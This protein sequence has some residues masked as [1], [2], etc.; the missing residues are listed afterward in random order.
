MD[1][2]LEVSDAGYLTSISP[3]AT[4]CNARISL[5]N[6]WMVWTFIPTKMAILGKPYHH[7]YGLGSVDDPRTSLTQEEVA[8]PHEKTV[9]IQFES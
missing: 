4:I 2:Y 8:G 7:V 9:G 1:D 5:W 3:F 6:E